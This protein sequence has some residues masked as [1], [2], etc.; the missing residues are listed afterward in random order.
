MRN[1]HKASVVLVA[2]FLS[3]ALL[4][5][6]PAVET[7][8]EEEVKVTYKT[9]FFLDVESKIPSGSAADDIFF[10]DVR[11]KIDGTHTFDA[12]EVSVSWFADE[13]CTQPYG[14]SE[15]LTE[16]LVLYGKIKDTGR[17]FRSNGFGWDVQEGKVYA[18]DATDNNYITTDEYISPSYTDETTGNASLSFNGAKYAVYGRGLDVTKPFTVNLNFT[19]IS[20]DNTGDSAVAWFEYS[21]FP[22]L[23]L[24]QAGGVN[25]WANAGAASVIMFNLGDGGTPI[26]FLRGLQI[27]GAKSSSVTEYPNVGADFKALFENGNTEIS[28]T[29]EITEEG[30][31]FTAGGKTVATSP[32]KQSDFSSGYAYISLATN[33]SANMGIEADVSVEQESGRI[34][35]SSDEGAET[36]EAVVSGMAVTLPITVKK[37]YELKSVQTGGEEITF[38]KLRGK[39]DVYAVDL[40]QWGRDVAVTVVT[41]KSAGEETS[42]C[43]SRIGKFGVAVSVFGLVCAA[44]FIFVGRK[45]S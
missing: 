43:G 41:Q 22:S 36:G 17:Y 4:S 16:D 7:L 23:T 13:A 14:F 31:T 21:L 44:A 27:A 3:A 40:P 30:T 20:A 45:I 42:G 33:G 19:N 29:V 39:E 18:G 15:A 26:S 9:P 2:V 6:I 38:V 34:T 10:S 11:G 28:L 32:A 37:G 8:A 1:R 12:A 35:V 5:G 24:A 25:T